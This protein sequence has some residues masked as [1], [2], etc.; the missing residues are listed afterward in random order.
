[1]TDDCPYKNENT[2]PCPFWDLGAFE[3]P[4]W[5][6][7]FGVGEEPPGADGMNEHQVQRAEEL[8]NAIQILEKSKS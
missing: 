4:D 8:D 5:R 6:R 1:M 7:C 2:D 3:C